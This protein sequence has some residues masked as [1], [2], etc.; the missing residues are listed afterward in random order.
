MKC[1][2]TFKIN[3]VTDS[4]SL[5]C[6]SFKT[7]LIGPDWTQM[8]Q[9]FTFWNKPIWIITI[10]WMHQDHSVKSHKPLQNS[11]IPGP[12][13]TFN[14]LPAAKTI[15]IQ[16]SG[17]SMTCHLKNVHT[18]CKKPTLGK[19]NGKHTFLR[20]KYFVFPSWPAVVYLSVPDRKIIVFYMQT[21]CITLCVGEETSGATDEFVPKTE[22]SL[23]CYHLVHPVLPLFPN[24]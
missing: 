20:R 18:R 19:L 13:A 22:D 9:T 7:L 2:Y 4:K 3:A 24:L 17:N 21:F 1:S 14:F 5:C 15:S 10:R 6:L 12:V 16:V 11:L 8:Q 23:K